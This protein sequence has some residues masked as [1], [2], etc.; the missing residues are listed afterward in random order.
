M[1]DNPYPLNQSA[2]GNGTYL[3][4]QPTNSQINYQDI[5][6][7]STCRYSSSQQLPFS[8][9]G[10]PPKPCK[11]NLIRQILHQAYRLVAD[12][13][14]VYFLVPNF[15]GPVLMLEAEMIAPII[16][17]IAASHDNRDV[18]DQNVRDALEIIRGDYPDFAEIGNGRTWL[19]NY[20][21]RYI[22]LNGKVMM[23]P[24]KQ[25]NM[26]QP[27]LAYPYWHPANCRPFHTVYIQGP[28]AMAPSGVRIIESYVPIPKDRDLLIYTFMVL[29]MMPERQQLVLELTGE[30]KS[31]MAQLQDVIKRTLDP[32]IKENAIRDTPSKV[33]DVDQ[34]AWRH[35][36]L[37]LDNV[38]DGLSSAVQRRMFELL[39]KSRLEWKAIGC[40]EITSSLAVR[41]AFL[42]SSLEPVITQ[43]ELVELT[44]S[45]EMP[46][47]STDQT[48]KASSQWHTQES[49]PGE[50]Q[51]RVFNALLGMLGKA[52]ANIGQVS[53]DRRVPD[54]WHDFCRIG[55]IVSDTLTGSA[56]A[57]WSQY[58]AYRNERLCEMT[59][60]EPIAKAVVEYLRINAITEAVENPAGVWLAILG[61]FRPT[62]VS[63]SQWPR[64][65]RGLG[66]AFKRA[67]PLLDAQ[68]IT[69]C[70]NGKRGSKRHWVIGPKGLAMQH[71]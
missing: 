14:G 37:N 45:L 23:L 54:G 53:L 67:A 3:P 64:E 12:P 62:C 58:E 25:E 2:T 10:R 15:G 60:E 16:K 63:D 33:K 70:S 41:R 59:E 11:A 71:F 48:G 34:K 61:Q 44:L 22:A 27:E 69:C 50:D 55:M 52:H 40:H 8:R 5:S 42:L 18:S 46:S 9:A 65:A 66:A 7:A 43:P 35:H 47:P 30:L 17:H 20:G 26:I 24:P 19:D 13:N 32:V 6:S 31:G 21:N 68:G 49:L 29:C 1:Y 4:N 56:E 51:S 28:S 38:E 36:V 39:C 57:F